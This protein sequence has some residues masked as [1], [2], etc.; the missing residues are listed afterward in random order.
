MAALARLVKLGEI[1]NLLQ[2]VMFTLY[3]NQYDEHEEHLL[4][5][6]FE[7]NYLSCTVSR[8]HAMSGWGPFF[9]CNFFLTWNEL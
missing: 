9:H 6:M 2:T 5:S 3:G 7:V 4:L 1:D 8:E